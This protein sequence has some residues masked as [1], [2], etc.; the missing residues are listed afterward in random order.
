M[1]L[2]TAPGDTPV[3]IRFADSGRLVKA[4]A[5]W[6]VTLTASLIAALKQTIG[7]DNVA[8]VE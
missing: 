4:P 1:V 7:D 6:S 8:V 2:S 5:E 3:Y